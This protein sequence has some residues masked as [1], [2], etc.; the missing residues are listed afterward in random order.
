MPRLASSRGATL[1]AL[2]SAALLAGIAPRAGADGLWSRLL[3]RTPD[4]LAAQREAAHRALEEKQ[5][6]LASRAALE[7][8]R[9][10]PESAEAHVLL[11]HARALGS[12]FARASD[13]YEQALSL[14]ER[15]LD[16]VRDASWASRAAVHAGRWQLAERTLRVFTERLPR[17]PARTLAF[18]RLGDVLQTLGR[19]EEATVA[20]RHALLDARDYLPPACLGLALAL[21]RSGRVDEARGWVARAAERASVEELLGATTGPEVERRARAELLAMLDEAPVSSHPSRSRAPR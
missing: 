16:A 12:D 20:Y 7:A 3:S 15:A 9:I 8:I 5:P 6:A 14:D 21:H 11:G 1:V 13:A 19:L 18:A 17:I 2:L 4:E 10:A